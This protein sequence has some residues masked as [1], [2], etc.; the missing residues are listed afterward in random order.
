MEVGGGVKEVSAP[1]SVQLLTGP[2][3]PSVCFKCG[4]NDLDDLPRGSEHLMSAAR[5]YEGAAPRCDSLAV[6]TR[7]QES[8]RLELGRGVGGLTARLRVP[9]CPPRPSPPPQSR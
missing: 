7:A 1:A 5:L 3:N 6:S 8:H 9:Y 2:W 4:P